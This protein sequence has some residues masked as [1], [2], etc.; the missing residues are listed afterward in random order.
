M[1]D[2]EAELNDLQAHI[3]LMGQVVELVVIQDNTHYLELR[4]EQIELLENSLQIQDLQAVQIVQLVNT[5]L[6]VQLLAQIE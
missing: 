6:L 3:R 1:L 5:Q 2:Q 4:A